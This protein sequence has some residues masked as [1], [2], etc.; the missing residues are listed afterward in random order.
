MKPEKSLFVRLS[1]EEHTRLKD[2]A[3]AQNQSMSDLV[4]LIVIEKING[5]SSL[6]VSTYEVVCKLKKD[7]DQ[8]SLATD[9]ALI[10]A[11]RYHHPSTDD[12]NGLWTRR[13]E[14][15]QAADKRMP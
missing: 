5:K 13:A 6:D 12:L 14:A 15:K 2:Y 9:A 10:A 4:R 7:L 8:L 3:K 11:C 1:L